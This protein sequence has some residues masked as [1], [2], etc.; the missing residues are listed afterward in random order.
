MTA[1]PPR[2]C[3][4]A[5]FAYPA[6][7]GRASGHIGGVERQTALMSRWF[8]ARG[9][10]VSVI[11]WDEGQPDGQE[12]DGVRVRTLCRQDAGLPGLRFVAPRW[13]TLARA[14]RRADADVY[15]QNCGEYVTGQVALWCGWR[16]RRFVYSVAS[17]MDCDPRLPEMQTRR[18]RALYR[19]GVRHADRVVVQ[20]RGQAAMLRAGF[21]REAQVIPMPGRDMAGEGQGAARPAGPRR[22]VLWLGRL[23]QVKRPERLLDLAERHRELDFD[24]VGPEDG[25]S[26]AWSIVQR[27]RALPNVRVHG[28][29]SDAQIRELLARALCLVSTSD[30]EGFPNTFLE[31]WSAGVPVVS[32]IDPDGVIDRAR[33]GG[34]AADV[35]GLSA[36]IGQ[37]AA[38]PE[39]C[40][41]IGGRARRYFVEHH[42]IDHVLPE[43]ERVFLDV[44]A[45]RRPRQPALA[46]GGPR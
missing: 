39:R 31:A 22:R 26:Y 1:R 42:S 2:L 18:E 28:R 5:H 10:D 19:Y 34:T 7:A 20:T 21:G 35:A 46:T 14:L 38:S 11:T 16:A 24:L 3:F 13:T 9:Y 29:A 30:F 41:E 27:A 15:Y 32:T 25:T 36:H 8:A 17:S 23:A 4:V 12:L 45:G 6:L 44:T 37:L 33:L 43:F 40:A